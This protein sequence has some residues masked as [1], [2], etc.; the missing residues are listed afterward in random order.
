VVIRGWAKATASR[1]RESIGF[2]LL[3]TA[4]MGRA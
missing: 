4:K 1:E 3:R 2:D